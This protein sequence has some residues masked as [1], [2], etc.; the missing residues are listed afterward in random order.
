M[1]PTPNTIS[2][3]TRFGRA[4]RHTRESSNSDSTKPSTT[5]TGTASGGAR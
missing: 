2:N 1:N 5:S 3:A 4:S